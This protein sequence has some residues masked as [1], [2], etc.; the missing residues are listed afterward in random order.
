MNKGFR[1]RIYTAGLFIV[2]IGMAC[3]IVMMILAPLG[4]QREDNK[5]HCRTY[6]SDYELREGSTSGVIPTM[7]VNPKTG[8]GK[9]L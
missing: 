1:N 5:Q 7:C 9:Y 6:G 3:L 2:A 4:K 8:E